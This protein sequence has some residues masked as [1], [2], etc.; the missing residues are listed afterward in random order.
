[1][2]AADDRTYEG[3]RDAVAEALSMSP[4]EVSADATLL[5]D[6]GAESIDL[7]DMLFRVDRKLGVKV[8]AAE[9]ASYVTGGMS[10]QE[11]GTPEGMVNDRGLAHLKMVMPQLDVEALAGKLP[12]EKVVTL[13]TVRNLADMIASKASAPVA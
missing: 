6:L 9:I 10:D 8:K 3:V 1:M 7:L 13:L 2:I 5:G 12:A 11:F 4:A